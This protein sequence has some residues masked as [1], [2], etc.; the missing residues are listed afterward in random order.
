MPGWK[1]QAASR[2]EV[3]VRFNFPT[4]FLA[5]AVVIGIPAIA[6]AEGVSTDC[7]DNAPGRHVSSEAIGAM[8]NGG[9]WITGMNSGSPRGG[10]NGTANA[11][12]F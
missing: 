8:R 10:P 11:G 7:N 4:F 1:S 5:A 2:K 3:T 6:S 9:D 12:P